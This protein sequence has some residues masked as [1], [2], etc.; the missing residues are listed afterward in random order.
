[1]CPS[2]GIQRVKT[3]RNAT[4]MAGPAPVGKESTILDYPD[5]RPGP[6]SSLMDMAT[7]SGIRP[8]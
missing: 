2:A 7:T 8:S 3:S 5:L 4:T 1:V 6:E